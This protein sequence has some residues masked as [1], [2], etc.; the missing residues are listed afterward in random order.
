ML[1][2]GDLRRS[3]RSDPT[4][5]W[6][7]S[8]ARTCKCRLPHGSEWLGESTFALLLRASLHRLFVVLRDLFARASRALRRLF[9]FGSRQVVGHGV[10]LRVGS[11]CVTCRAARAGGLRVVG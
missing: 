8:R 11:L 5:Q 10:D 7:T 9:L 6:S 2:D 3:H 1:L 4:E